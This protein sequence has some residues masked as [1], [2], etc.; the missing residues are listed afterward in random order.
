MS[1]NRKVNLAVMMFLNLKSKFSEHITRSS[2]A[3]CGVKPTKIPYGIALK[4]YKRGV[5]IGYFQ[6]FFFFFKTLSSSAYH[7]S[8]NWQRA[9]RVKIMTQV[10]LE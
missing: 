10:Q 1:E 6:I 5:I 4:L 8:V 9:A 3:F 7:I 2:I